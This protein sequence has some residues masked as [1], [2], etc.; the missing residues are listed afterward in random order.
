M[1]EC[2]TEGPKFLL[3]FMSNVGLND[4]IR[5]YLLKYL[6]RNEPLIMNS[7]GFSVYRSEY[8]YTLATMWAYHLSHGEFKYS[9]ICVWLLH[10]FQL[11]IN[12]IKYLAKIG[13]EC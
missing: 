13:Y 12:L 8:L 2:I 1:P 6:E 3:T 4:E 5:E 9:V 7:P 11:Y 10:F